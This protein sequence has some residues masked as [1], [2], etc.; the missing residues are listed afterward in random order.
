MSRT[1]RKNESSIIEDLTKAQK[2]IFA[3]LA[4]QALTSLIEMGIIE[5]LDKQPVFKYRA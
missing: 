2:F 5:F 4:F 1:K 3:P